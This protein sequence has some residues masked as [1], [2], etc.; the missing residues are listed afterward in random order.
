M[1]RGGDHAGF[2]CVMGMHANFQ[3]SETTVFLNF[4]KSQTYLE[5]QYAETS[6]GDLSLFLNLSVYVAWTLRDRNLSFSS[7]HSYS[8]LVPASHEPQV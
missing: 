4:I 6:L 8:P 1:G 2:A 3:R 5:I 7:A